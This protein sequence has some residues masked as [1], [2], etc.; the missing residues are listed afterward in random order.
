MKSLCALHSLKHPER[1]MELQTEDKR[2]ERD[3][4]DPEE[5]RGV[6]SRETDLTSNQIPKCSPQPRIPKEIHRVG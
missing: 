1:F 4:G 3:T 5:K 6:K 2:E